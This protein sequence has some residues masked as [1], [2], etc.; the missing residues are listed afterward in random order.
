MLDGHLGQEIAWCCD[1]ES[2]V[3]SANVY[4][5][6]MLKF[7]GLNVERPAA[8]YLVLQKP[9][10][11]S[12]RGRWRVSQL[13]TVHCHVLSQLWSRPVAVDGGEM[14]GSAELGFQL[15]SPNRISGRSGF[16]YNHVPSVTKSGVFK[17]KRKWLCLICLHSS[18]SV[19]CWMTFGNISLSCTVT[20]SEISF[21]CDGGRLI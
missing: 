11:H 15:L 4:A 6:G 16:Y 20:S 14:D 18:S 21:F 17:L 5:D 12:M 19:A 10:N 2:N 3:L 8:G 1:P 7:T 9:I 13:C